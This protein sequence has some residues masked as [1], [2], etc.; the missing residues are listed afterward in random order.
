MKTETDNTL[1][2]VA[3]FFTK[4]YWELWSKSILRF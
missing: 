2:Q 3:F 4:L 1:Y